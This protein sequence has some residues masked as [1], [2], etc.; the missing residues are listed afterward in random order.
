MRLKKS[1]IET[2][3]TY[4]G[5]DQLEITPLPKIVFLTEN[6]NDVA[7]EHIRKNTGLEFKKTHWLG[8]EAQPTKSNQITRLFLTYNFKTQYHDNANNHNTLFLKSD[9]HIGFKVDHICYAC[10][11][12]NN[13]YTGDMK[14]SHR[15]SC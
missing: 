12:A 5:N 11:K 4:N 15:L 9:H 2:V 13:I 1:S 3:R 7:L 10:C 6:I 14:K 8:Y